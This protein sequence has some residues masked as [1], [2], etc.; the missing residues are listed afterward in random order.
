MKKEGTQSTCTECKKPYYVPPSARQK[1]S[2]CSRKC[3]ALGQSKWQ[4]RD[5]SER[6]WEKVEKTESCWLWTG[7][8]L[9]TGYGSVRVGGKA[10]R[11]HRVAY[12]LLVGKI[13]D[14]MLLRHSC[15][16][17]KCVNPSHLIP[18]TKRQNTEDALERGQHVC[19]E[20]HF[21]SKLDNRSVTTIRAALAAGVSGKFLAEQFRVSRS[22]ISEIKNG[23]KRK[24]G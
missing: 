21:R 10:L 14:G 13:P 23:N 1:R 20:D 12:E 9:K 3:R 17:P 18:G 7:G 2:Y 22:L 5:L 19:G 8:L 11:A 15:D 24:F 16:N 6:F 4:K